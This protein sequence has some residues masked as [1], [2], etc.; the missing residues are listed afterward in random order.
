MK[1]NGKIA[2]E[3]VFEYNI[4]L[5][6]TTYEIQIGGVFSLLSKYHIVKVEIESDE[7]Y[8]PILLWHTELWYGVG[9]RDDDNSLIQATMNE[10]SS[11]YLFLYQGNE[12]Y[13][14]ANTY[15]VKFTPIL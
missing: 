10:D 14:T 11:L 13:L 1:S 15:S 6:D 4:E 8:I 9:N 3:N 5:D 12:S 7:L 2:L